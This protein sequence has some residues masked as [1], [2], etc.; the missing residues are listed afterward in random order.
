MR[1]PPLWIETGRFFPFSSCLSSLKFV[2]HYYCSFIVLAL[3][4]LYQGG[5][6]LALFTLYGGYIRLC[7][8]GNIHLG[9][10]H[11]S[12]YW[13]H[14]QIPR[15]PFYWRLL[16]RSFPCCG[17]SRQLS[18]SCKIT[19]PPTILPIKLGLRRDSWLASDSQASLELFQK[20][21]NCNSALANWGR[22]NLVQPH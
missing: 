3:S 6:C 14:K 11:N 12:S 7:E 5:R 19:P 17:H 15:N 13:H 21:T 16:Q 10:D 1:H 9:F 4:F 22:H 2:P 18:G 8:A 20:L